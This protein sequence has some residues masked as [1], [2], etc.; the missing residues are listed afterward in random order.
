[1]FSSLHGYDCV[2]LY[3]VL[4]QFLNVLFQMYYILVDLILSCSSTGVQRIAQL[5]K[6]AKKLGLCNFL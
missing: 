5:L 1:M 6:L 3:V 2:V 4:V